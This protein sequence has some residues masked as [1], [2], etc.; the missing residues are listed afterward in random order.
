MSMLRTEEKGDVLVV[1]FGGTRILDLTDWIEETQLMELD[2]ARPA[3]RPNPVYEF[4][5]ELMIAAGRATTKKLV[6][7]FQQ[8]VFMSDV[9]GQDVMGMVILLNKKC[10]TDQ[11]DLKICSISPNFMELFRVMRLQKVF[12]IFDDEAKAVAA[13]NQGT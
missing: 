9:M 6:L 13:F 7:N 8:V 3:P 2:A 5:R 10:K 11:I 4:G 12:D 1:Y